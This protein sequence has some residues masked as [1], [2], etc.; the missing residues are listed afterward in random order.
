M[1]LASFFDKT[2]LSAATLL[3]GFNRSAFE[4]KLMG[5]NVGI[6]FDNNPVTDSEQLVAIELLVN[7]LARL[8]PTISLICSDSGELL[9]RMRSLALQI[10]PQIEIR[11]TCTDLSM[12]VAT[13]NSPP[14]DA[15]RAQCPIVFLGSDG[16]IAKVSTIASMDWGCSP[17]PFGAA[18]AACLGAANVFRY[19]FRDQLDDPQ[20]DENLALS[21]FDYSTNPIQEEQPSLAPIDLSG[22][23]LIGAGAIGNA[24]IWILRRLSSVHGNL[25]VVDHEFIEL[26][27]L[28]RYVLTKNDSVGLSKVNLAKQAMENRELTVQTFA[29]KWSNYLESSDWNLPRLAVAVDTIQER[30]NISGS[31]AKEVLNAWTQADEVGISRHYKYGEEACLSCLYF[32]D[33]QVPSEADLVG[34]AIGL[35]QEIMLVRDLLQTGKPV[36]RPFLERVAVALGIPVDELLA[37]EGKNLR[38]FYSQ[39]V[40]GGMV[41]RLG[42]TA[43]T[44]TEVPMAFQS[45]LA[46]IFLAAEIVIA[47]GGMRG[48]PIPN[49]TRLRVSGSISGS[50]LTPVAVVERCICQDLD[51][52]SVYKQ[53]YCA[54]DRT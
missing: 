15:V 38:H 20:S 8:Y 19:I 17:N 22:T 18:A 42:A 26:S 34:M 51:F 36:D 12:V 21:L 9:D 39:A 37:F 7:L 30:V 33:G 43:N 32:P 24:V 27:N 44:G 40:C 53:K 6:V 31:L 29:E 35:P 25:N 49:T 1:A 23:A 52:Q 46:G 4:Q 11:T 45:A 41:F 2:A 54:I 48:Q 14:S 28:Q 10:N 47:A 50:L 16:W 5:V 13:V 3:R